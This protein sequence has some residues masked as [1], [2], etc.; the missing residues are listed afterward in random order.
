MTLAGIQGANDRQ[1]GDALDMALHPDFPDTGYVDAI[2]AV[3][4][5]EAAG[6]SGNDRRWVA[7]T[8]TPAFRASGRK[9]PRVSCAPWAGSE[10][11]S[12]RGAGQD[13]GDVSGSGALESTDPSAVG[14]P[15]SDRTFDADD[16][17]VDGYRQAIQRCARAR[18][19]PSPPGPA[20]RFTCPRATG[21][22]ST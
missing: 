21:P 9:R 20:A 2:Y 7:A 12:I 4:P 22:R 14:E 13:D 3:H 15:A 10:T 18:A 19:A 16:V 17:V 11:L 1:D 6:L 8:T 5:P